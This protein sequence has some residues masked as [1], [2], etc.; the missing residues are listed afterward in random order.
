MHPAFQIPVEQP[1]NACLLILVSNQQ[2][3]F[4]WYSKKPCRA[5]G[6]FIFQLAQPVT[7]A[8]WKKLVESNPALLAETDSV[9][10]LF[11]LKES[12]LVP[13]QYYDKQ[14]SSEL[15]A[16]LFGADSRAAI[17]V[18]AMDEQH[19]T[20]LYR[21]PEGLLEEIRQTYPH[22]QFSD[23]TSI[24]VRKLSE[25]TPGLFAYFHN[26]QLKVF[27]FHH[28]VLQFMQYFTYQTA[29]DAAYHLL[30]T[31]RHFGLEPEDVRL[32]LAGM[33]EKRSPLFTEIQSLFTQVTFDLAGADWIIPESFGQY[34]IHYF[35]HLT[36]LASCAS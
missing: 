36:D 17:C 22:A 1:G 33:I 31:C 9:T 15:L 13:S 24:Q 21:I 10:V 2:L 28:G 35:S 19:I 6:L 25:E 18:S 11:D 5:E 4:F 3:S 16:C 7:A 20:L 34:P 32:R 26:Q 30:N 12:T 27:L 14:A 8:G 29:S 23:A